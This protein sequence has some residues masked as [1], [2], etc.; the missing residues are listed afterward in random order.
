MIS[1]FATNGQAPLARPSTYIFTDGERPSTA[2]NNWLQHNQYA[3]NAAQGVDLVDQMLK[4]LAPITISS[5][6]VSSIAYSPL[7]KLLCAVGSH[8]TD[9]VSTSPDGEN[10]TLQ[11][12]AEANS[13]NHVVWAGGSINLFVALASNGTNRIMTSPDGVNWTSASASQ[14]NLWVGLAWSEYL[15]LLVAVAADGTNRV[16]T[17]PDGINWTN[18][19]A[20]SASAWARVTW[21]SHL[22]L[23]V[24]TTSGAGPVAMYS[25]DG[26]TWH[27]SSET[28][29][30]TNRFSLAWSDYFKLF[31][32]EY[33]TTDAWI[34]GD[35]KTWQVLSTPDNCETIL[36]I[37]ALGCLLLSDGSSGNIYVTSD[38]ETFQL[39]VAPAGVPS[40]YRMY[41]TE[42]LNRIFILSL[43]ST[44]AL[45]SF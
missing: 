10:W 13:W 21:S 26:V 22:K 33:S 34:S 23:F 27:L 30:G 32:H 3:M 28:A 4:S 18:R 31:F 42:E 43:G 7:L 2:T 25:Y 45:A 36:P 37:D 39:L 5:A 16:M 24:A 6:N 11:T 38:L 9:Y 14:A 44:D 35:G 40:L 17:S 20:A 29:A 19:T 12:G 1:K 41:Y 8:P 15:N